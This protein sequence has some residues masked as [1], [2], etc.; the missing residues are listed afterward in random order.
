VAVIADGTRQAEGTEDTSK[1]TSPGEIPRVASPVWFDAHLLVTAHFV[2]AGR[3]GGA[4][5]MLY[6]LLTGMT[7][8]IRQLSV[9][10]GDRGD[11]DPAFVGVLDQCRSA[12]LLQAG[13]RGS[14]FIAEQRAS[15]DPRITADAILFPNYFV[16]PL[17][18]NRLGR[19]VVVMHDMQYRH[20]PQYFTARKRAWLRA[21]HSLALR[22]ADK[23]IVISEFGRKDAIR[24][25]GNSAARKLTVI[26]NPVSWERFGPPIDARPLD[27][28]YILSVAAQYP[29]KNLGVLMRAFAELSRRDRDVLLV[30]CGRDYKGLVGVAPREAGI[31]QLIAELGIGDRV[32]AV[33]YVDDVSLGTWYRHALCFAFPSVFEGFGMP[34]VE[35][36]GF[37]LPTLMSRCTALPETSLGLGI[38]VDDP[39]NVSEWASRLTSIARNGKALRPSVAD[40]TMLRS[41]YDPGRIA[42]LYLDACL[43]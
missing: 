5:H 12:C 37:G 26:P 10:C 8:R 22:R 32:R 14:R 42:A 29:H 11:L 15:L 35:A 27:R 21:A 38:F 6:N 41:H 31:G 4:E 17:V 34:T 33:G 28:P 20:F 1:I 23:M 24:W 13:G 19:I 40:T 25:L 39:M 9:V 30:L 43:R 2:R 7:G 3:V 18:S 16:P 36:L